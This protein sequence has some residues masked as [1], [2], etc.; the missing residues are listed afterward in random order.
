MM[1]GLQQIFENGLKLN[2]Q[3]IRLYNCLIIFVVHLNHKNNSALLKK[4]N[5]LS[6]YFGKRFK[7]E[8]L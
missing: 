6:H 1:Y 5:I 3:L 8:K 4:K 7:A 2:K